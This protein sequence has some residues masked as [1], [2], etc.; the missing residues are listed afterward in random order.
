MKLS[1]KVYRLHLSVFT[2]WDT[3][4]LWWC[5]N[6]E[7]EKTRNRVLEIENR[8]ESNQIW[9]IQTDSALSHGL[10]EAY[11]VGIDVV[12]TGTS[13]E[14]AASRQDSLRLE[15]YVYK[16]VPAMQR[17]ECPL[18]WWAKNKA[19]YPSVAAVARRMLAI[20]A[21]SVPRTACEGSTAGAAEFPFVA[22]T[23]FCD[24]RSP[25]HDLPLPPIFFT[26]A[27]CS[28]PTHQIFGP[29]RFRS[30]IASHRQWLV[31]IADNMTD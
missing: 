4:A 5:A 23:Y 10:T 8:T 1:V 22:Q 24:S 20:P 7:T 16:E 9:K 17:A 25:L 15:L 2:H 30:L 29:H 26:P 18:S 13:F 31:R 12:E 11:T 6:T 19:T 3:L 21:T 14:Y 27:Q 28:A